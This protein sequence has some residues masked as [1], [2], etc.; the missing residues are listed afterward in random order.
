LLGIGRGGPEKAG[1]RMGDEFNRDGGHQ[2]FK[3]A[4]GAETFGKA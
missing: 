4:F 3:S 2:S 1:L